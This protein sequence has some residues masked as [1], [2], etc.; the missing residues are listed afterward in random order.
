MAGDLGPL[1]PLLVAG[2]AILVFTI[3]RPLSGELWGI[4]LNLVAILI[5]ALGGLLGAANPQ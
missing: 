4:S 2:L 3:S 1:G 5:I